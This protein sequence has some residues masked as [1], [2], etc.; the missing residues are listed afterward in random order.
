MDKQTCACEFFKN[1]FMCSQSVLAAFCEDYGLPKETAFKLTRFLGAGYAY[2][3]EVC[4]AVSGALMVYG[5]KYGSADPNDTH[6]KE[7]VDRLS[8]E[9]IAEFIRQF[10]SLQCKDILGYDVSIPA[11][12]EESRKTGIFQERCP[13]FI[14]ASVTI[15]EQALK[16]Q[17]DL[18]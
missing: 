9:H 1:G 12:L 6:S 16:K 8:R 7:I 3:G 5:L 11:Q 4:G 10:G 14:K 17:Q 13:L 2:R 18:Q 15:L